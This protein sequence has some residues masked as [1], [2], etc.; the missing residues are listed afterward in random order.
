MSHE[1]ST[2][3]NSLPIL[4]NLHAHN[5]EGN[6]NEKQIE[7]AHTIH[8]AGSDLLSLINDI[9]DLSKVE[10]GKM[11]VHPGHVGFDAVKDYVDRSF[12]AVAEQKA[13]GFEVSMAEDLPK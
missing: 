12:R 2:P 1:L 6:L 7:F 13:L 10:A 11:E 5:E 3:R 8:T 4:Y 9:L